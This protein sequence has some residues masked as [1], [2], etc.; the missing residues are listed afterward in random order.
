MVDAYS[1]IKDIYARKGMVCI[2]FSDKNYTR[3]NEITVD[4]AL[5]RSEAIGEMT[6]EN[7]V[8]HG[9]TKELA[10]TLLQAASDARNQQAEMM[11]SGEFVTFRLKEKN[12]RML[13]L[14]RANGNVR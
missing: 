12:K 2:K 14:A 8:R 11:K 4:E 9:E 7:E 10:Q 3:I 13:E 6:T 5:D 1:L